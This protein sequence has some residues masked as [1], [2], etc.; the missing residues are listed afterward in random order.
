MT[1]PVELLHDA[2]AVITLVDG[3]F[4]LTVGAAVVDRRPRRPAGGAARELNRLAFAN[5]A[6][7]VRHDYDLKLDEPYGSSNA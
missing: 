1:G 5:G 2:D 7:S 4:V 6:N 3:D